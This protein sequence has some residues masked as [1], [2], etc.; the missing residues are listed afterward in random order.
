MKLQKPLQLQMDVYKKE[1]VQPYGNSCIQCFLCKK[2]LHWVN[3][4]LCEF[5]E[6]QNLMKIRTNYTF[7]SNRFSLLSCFCNDLK[8]CKCARWDFTTQMVWCSP[9]AT[10]GA[11]GGLPI[12]NKAPSPQSETWNTINQLRFC[13][14]LKCQAPPHKPKAPLLKTFCRRFWSDGTVYLRTFIGSVGCKECVLLAAMLLF[15]SRFFIHC[16]HQVWANL[17]SRRV[18]CRKPKAPVSRKT[19]L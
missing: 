16:I 12:P 11:F 7:N 19:S 14:F 9:V 2:T 5:L 3:H 4:K 6:V 8:C 10:E 13:Q 1:N 15:Y 17:F 18:I